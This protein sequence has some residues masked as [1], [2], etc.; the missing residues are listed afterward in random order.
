MTGGSDIFDL[1]LRLI[2]E[3]GET[4]VASVFTATFAAVGDLISSLLGTFAGVR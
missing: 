3:A 1:A 2:T 4:G